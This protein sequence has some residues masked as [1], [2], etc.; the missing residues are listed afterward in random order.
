MSDAWDSAV[1]LDDEWVS[2][3]DG[4]RRMGITLAQLDELIRRGAI[5]ARRVGWG[6]EVQ[7]AVTNV[8]ASV[9]PPATAAR[10]AVKKAAGARRASK[11][12]PPKRGGT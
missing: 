12:A 3:E 1:P 6:V 2:P 7:P 5:R 4:A 10:A 8:E 9:A 11:T